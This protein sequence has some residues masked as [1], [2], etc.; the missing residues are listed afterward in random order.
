MIVA[1]SRGTSAVSSLLPEAVGMFL[2][3]MGVVGA[4]DQ[5]GA[6]RRESGWLYVLFLVTA[7][8]PVTFRLGVCSVAP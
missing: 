7:V 5:N 1:P 8:Q 6:R 4:G 2:A 3:E